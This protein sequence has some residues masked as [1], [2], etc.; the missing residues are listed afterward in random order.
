[1]DL[2]LSGFVKNDG[3]LLGVVFEVTGF[4]FIASHYRQSDWLIIR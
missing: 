1:M 4:T 2:F 3:R